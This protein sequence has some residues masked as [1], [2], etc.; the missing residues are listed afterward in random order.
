MIAIGA[1]SPRR[2]IS[3]Y[4]YIR[5]DALITRGYFIKQLFDRGFI[6]E[7]GQSLAAGM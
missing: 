1:A 5:P 6:E 3:E 4:G 7:I 2:P